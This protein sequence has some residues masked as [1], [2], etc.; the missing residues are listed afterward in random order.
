MKHGNIVTK[1]MAEDLQTPQNNHK[2]TAQS[3]QYY[4]Y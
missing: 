1:S 2:V 3:Q 4:Y